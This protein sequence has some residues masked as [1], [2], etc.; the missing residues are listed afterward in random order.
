M[1]DLRAKDLLI[2]ENDAVK[3]SA[4]ISYLPSFKAL[5]QKHAIIEESK[6]KMSIATS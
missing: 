1:V 4:E 5:A 6:H 3:I 2:R